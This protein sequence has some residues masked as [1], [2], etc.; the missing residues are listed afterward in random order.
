MVN[1]M[2]QFNRNISEMKNGK[3]NIN[4]IPQIS[5]AN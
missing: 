3:G 2:K 5:N 1:M 4:N